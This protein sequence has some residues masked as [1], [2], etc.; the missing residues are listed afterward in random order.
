MITFLL[1]HFIKEF[2]INLKL[3]SQKENDIQNSEVILDREES[4]PLLVSFR[5]FHTE[6]DDIRNSQHFEIMVPE[7]RNLLSR[8]QF[9]INN[10]NKN[11]K[12]CQQN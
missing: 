10:L 5:K 9:V 6:L 1:T 11:I 12:Y 4:W 3:S 7:K 8:L 2:L